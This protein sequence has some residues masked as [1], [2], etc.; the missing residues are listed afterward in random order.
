MLDQ[1]KIKIKRH[2]RRFAVSDR[3]VTAVE[4]VMVAPLMFY[5]LSV[6][7]EVFIMQFA[8]S[9]ITAA[10]EDVART[11]RTG[12]A[13]M[14]AVNATTFKSNIC[15]ILGSNFNCAGLNV[16]VGSDTSFAN[17]VANTPPVLTIGPK[18]DATVTPAKA[19]YS[20]GSPKS[21]AIVIATY[22]W[23]FATPGLGTIIGNIAGN[24]GKRMSATTLFQNQNYPGSATA[25][26]QC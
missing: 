14:S 2:W 18:T 23:Y 17:L 20:P 11:V 22:D 10:V 4:F 1:L 8:Q 9:Q 6:T 7:M 24:T 16:Y 5:T 3:G 25:I 19:C 21:P 26:T 13:Q 12:A 15:A